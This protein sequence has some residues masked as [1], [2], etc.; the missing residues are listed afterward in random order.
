MFLIWKVSGK[1]DV[2][3]SIAVYMCG[4]DVIQYETEMT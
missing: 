4:G 3:C 2:F 1:V